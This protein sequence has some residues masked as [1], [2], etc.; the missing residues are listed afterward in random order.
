MLNGEQN[1]G[2]LGSLM[3]EYAIRYGQRPTYK[4]IA[5]F[6]RLISTTMGRP[7]CCRGPF[8]VYFCVQSQNGYFLS[9]FIPSIKIQGHLKYSVGLEWEFL[10]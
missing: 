8:K 10:N 7:H 3:K 4:K 6:S 2:V 1:L 9:A 5:I